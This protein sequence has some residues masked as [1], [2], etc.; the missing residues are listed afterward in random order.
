MAAN[1]E[2]AVAESHEGEARNISPIVN[3]AQLFSTCTECFGLIHPS[4]DW[5]RAQLLVLCQLGIQQ[6]RLLAWGDNV[7]ICETGPLRDARLDDPEKRAKI[8]EALQS[9]IDRPVHVHRVTQFEKYGLKPPKKLSMHYQPALDT[10]R[11]EVF[12]E[13]FEMLNHERWEVRRG[14]S[15]TA[16]HWVVHDVERFKSFIT[17]VRDKIDSLIHMMGNEENVDRAVKHDIRA[18]GWHP[19]FDKL[20]ASGDTSKLRLIREACKTDYPEYSAVTEG[21]LAYIEREWRENYQD[22][23]QRSE[24]RPG[25]LAVAP[26]TDKTKASPAKK[27]DSPKERR[28]SLFKAFKRGWKKGPHD[29][30]PADPSNSVS[31]APSDPQRSKS[32]AAPSGATQTPSPPLTPERSKSIQHIPMRPPTDEKA[33][34]EVP[35]LVT[36]S[37]DFE[38]SA[39]MN[40][41]GL[42]LVPTASS[43]EGGAINP[44]TSMISRHD[45]AKAVH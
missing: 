10:T 44:V 28:P 38:P 43:T 16:N 35:D 39:D 29:M 4:K 21:A 19:I 30:T 3:L 18:L 22:A 27:P 24:A 11:L 15:I 13:K 5:E 17:L 34:D 12:R 2:A 9:I 42:S 41:G 45:Q 8:E 31:E 14:M 33:V 1:G 37:R 6:A 25:L 20:K 7:G 23:R 26:V 32:V 36:R 40:G